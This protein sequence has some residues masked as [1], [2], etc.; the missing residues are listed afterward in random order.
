MSE[1]FTA[2]MHLG[3]GNIIAYCKRPWLQDG[4][5]EELPEGR[6]RWVSP[7]I[8][9]A[10]TVAMNRA[11]V[12]FWNETVTAK[13]TVKHLGD[14]CLHRRDSDEDAVYW[15][16]KLNGKLIHFKGNHD[17]SREIKGMLGCAT[18]K[19]GG[20]EFLLQHRPPERIEE[21]PDFC[22][23]V[24]CGHVHEAWE[25]KWIGSLL[26]VNVGVDVWNFRPVPLE[27]IVAVVD[28]LQHERKSS[29][30]GPLPCNGGS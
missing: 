19:A 24:L 20:H 1:L 10:R 7:E 18:M 2:D 3:H 26:V 22:D 13:D 28:K 27:K 29:G 30:L 4:D 25:H 23:V 9:E 16:K 6:V 15:E 14:F 17:R 21:V 11:L 12:Q 8:K 5:V